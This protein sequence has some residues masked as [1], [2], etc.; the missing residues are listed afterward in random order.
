V[1]NASGGGFLGF[2]SKVGK[3]ERVMLDGLKKLLQLG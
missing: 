2:G 3:E 1:A